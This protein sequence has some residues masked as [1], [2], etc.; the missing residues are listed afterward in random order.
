MLFD[1][2]DRALLSALHAGKWARALTSFGQWSV[3]GY[4][5]P[6][7]TRLSR[8]ADLGL[9]KWDGSIDEAVITKAG[10]QAL[11]EEPCRKCEHKRSSHRNGRGKCC[12]PGRT[13]R[14][15]HMCSCPVWRCK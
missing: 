11:L 9:V 14:Q 1:T 13:E 15:W 12:A 6:A 2:K 7:E 4:S 8:L 3:I 10:A 5:S